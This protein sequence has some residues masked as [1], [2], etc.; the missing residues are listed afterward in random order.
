MPFNEPSFLFLL[1]P[2][3][4]ALYCLLPAGRAGPRN[5]WLLAV[6]VVFY[7][8]GG[9]GC[10]FVILGAVVL[11]YAAALA[12]GRSR[13]RPR[14]RRVLALA[15]TANLGLLGWF[16]YA[17]FLGANLDALS[18]RLGLGAL[19]VPRMVLPLGISFF[20]FRAISYVV[21]VY[22]GDAV[23]QRHPVRAA[24]YLLL[25]PQLIAGPISRYRHMADQLGA[26][27]VAREQFA[28]GIRRFVFGL[29]KKTLIASA[30][31][32]VAD[33]IFALPAGELHAG[34]AWL[35]A[36]AYT[37]QIYF[38]FS[39]YTDMAIGLGS[40]LGFKFP[41]NF[42]YPYAAR[43]IREFWRRWHLT[44]SAWLRDYLYIPLGGNRVPPARVYVNLLIV[45]FLCGL[46]HGA[47]WRFVVWGLYHGVFLILERLGLGNALERTW[48]PLRHLY[49]LLVV[50]V[51]WVFFRAHTLPDAVHYL[52]A[53][54][55]VAPPT[56]ISD[57]IG[58]YLDPY[59]LTALIVGAVAALPVAPAFARWRER[60]ASL[61]VGWAAGFAGV[62]LLGLALLFIGSVMAMAAQ[63]HSPFIYFQF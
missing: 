2:L 22:R 23:A 28:A 15:V 5:A 11:N 9:K 1:L 53:M 41:E 6:S 16:K 21:D 62:S 30:V 40:M 49:A 26:R 27:P 13:E 18:T 52:G 45:F 48:R 10:V 51:G 58:A 60:R 36:A 39:G 12:I 37:L 56:G 59:V 55:A 8:W 57:G 25:F 46:W 17:G 32:P 14:G 47:S 33:R 3:T 42:D 31:G 19:L 35:G 29:G 61:S 7:A 24:L 63:T 4:L 20:T 43:S 44:L 34:V 38:D 54:F 50:M